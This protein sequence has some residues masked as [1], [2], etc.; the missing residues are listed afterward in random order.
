MIQGYNMGQIHHMWNP[1]EFG[2]MMAI[3]KRTIRLAITKTKE[4]FKKAA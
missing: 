4:A 3:I 1:S 2:G